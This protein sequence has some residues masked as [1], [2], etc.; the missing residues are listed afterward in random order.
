[1]QGSLSA[2]HL[3]GTLPRGSLPSHT[4]TVPR[5]APMGGWGGGGLQ[6]LYH[7]HPLTCLLAASGLCFPKTPPYFCNKDSPGP[8][9][10]LSATALGEKQ[11]RK[12]SISS[13]HYHP[14]PSLP[15]SMLVLANP[16]T[17]HPSC[18][19]G[20]PSIPHAPPSGVSILTK[21]IIL[22]TD[23]FQPIFSVSPSPPS[24]C[25]PPWLCRGLQFLY[26]HSLC[27]IGSQSHLLQCLSTLE[28]VPVAWQPTNQCDGELCFL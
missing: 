25:T 11:A 26:P 27:P 24:P 3:R 21:H 18:C 23:P 16:D 6:S 9:T 20:P 28:A 2:T 13:C 12:T 15:L 22:R 14:Q 8:S 4:H 5:N 10:S 19:S 17:F 7:K 1:M